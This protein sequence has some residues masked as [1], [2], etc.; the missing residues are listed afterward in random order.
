MSNGVPSAASA[1]LTIMGVTWRRFARGRA[2]WVALVIAMFPFVPASLVHDDDPV[3][4]IQMLVMGL[5]PPVFVASAI[6]EEIEE[7]TSTYL[8]SRPLPRW[9]LLAGKVLALAPIAAGLIALGWFVS[10]QT[11]T[12][13]PPSLRSTVAFAAG[14][15][16]ISSMS[17]GIGTLVPKHGMALSIIYFLVI[18]LAVGAIPASVQKISITYHVRQLAG[19]DDPGYVVEPVI[20]IAI[21]SC[22]WLGVGLW[23]VRRL[24]S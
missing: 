6:A 5:L 8:W 22:M 4:I 18:D 1:L 11:A 7:R 16:A 14:A 3:M 15:L 20:A 12:G 23:R 2:V 24:E 9:T 17:A 21:L 19:L 13:H 10:M